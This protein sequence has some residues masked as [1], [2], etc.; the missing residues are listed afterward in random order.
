[1]HIIK[2]MWLYANKYDADGNVIQHK[3][4]LIA[5]GFLQIPGLEYDQTYASVVHL[6]SFQMVAAIAASL[7]IYGKSTSYPLSSTA[8]TSSQFICTS[9]QVLSN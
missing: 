3:A 6:K 8:Q 9:H 1:M 5:K 2:S 4:H 7:N